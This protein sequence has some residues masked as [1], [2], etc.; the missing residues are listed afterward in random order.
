MFFI[1]IYCKN[2][3]EFQIHFTSFEITILNYIKKISLMSDP[4]GSYYW[5]KSLAYVD[6]NTVRESLL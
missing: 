3:S 4:S 1:H 6:K 2:Q 5:S